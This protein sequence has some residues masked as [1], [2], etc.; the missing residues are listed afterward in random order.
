MRDVSMLKVYT[1]GRLTIELHDEGSVTFV[2]QKAPVLLVYLLMHPREHSR[3]VLAEMF[4]SDTTTPQALKNLR[5]VLSNLQKL[6]GDYLDVTRQTLAITK[7]ESIWFDK[8]AFESR[9]DEIG[10]K[11]KHPYSPRKLIAELAEAINL[12]QGDFLVGVKTS[13]APQLDTWIMLEQERL[14]G[15]VA[16]AM[17]K[18][19]ELALAS[20]YYEQGIEYGRKLLAIEPLWEEAHRALMILLVKSGNRT[21]ALQQY[22]ACVKIL[23]IELDIEPDEETQNVYRD[24]KTGRIRVSTEP[25]QRPTNLQQP[26]TPYVA[27]PSVIEKI[28][29]L[30][31]N[32][33]CRLVTIMGQGGMGKTRLSQ[34]LGLQRLEDYLDGVYFVPLASVTVPEVLPLAILDALGVDHTDSRLS[35]L[36]TLLSLLRR[37]HVLLILDNFEHLMNKADV[38]STILG[39][40]PYVQIVVTSREQLH[41]QGEH[42][43]YLRALA[44]AES[45]KDHSSF[46]AGELFVQMAKLAQVDFDA[47]PHLEA[48][49]H[50]CQLVDGL[51]LAIVIAAAWVRFLPPEAIAERIR[52]SLEFLTVERRDFPEHH[53]GIMAL[54]RMTWADLSDHERMIMM[55]IAVFPGDF[56]EVAAETISSATLEDMRLLVSKSLLQADGQGRYFLHE[57]LRRFALEQSEADNIAYETRHAHRNYY[58]AWLEEQAE[59]HVPIHTLYRKIDHE[60]HNVTCIDW[61]EGEDFHHAVLDHAPIL[62]DYWVMRGYSLAEGVRLLNEALP[63]ADNTQQKAHALY[64]TGQLLARMQQYDDSAPLL[65]M[66]LNH[67]REVGDVLLEAKILN[68]LYRVLGAQGD[69]A[70][71]RLNLLEMV[72]VVEQDSNG[73]EKQFQQILSMAYSNLGIVHM[74]MDDPVDAENYTRQALNLKDEVTDPVGTAL[75]H[76]TL[77]V[78]ALKRD[79]YDEAEEQ[80]REALRIASDVGHTRHQ[81]IYSGN[82]AEVLHKQGQYEQAYRMYFDTLQIAYQI[83]NNKTCLNVLEQLTD[84]ALDMNQPE[85]AVRLLGAANKLRQ[86]TGLA[87]EPRQQSEVNRR[88]T[89]LQDTVSPEA[90]MG[91]RTLDDVMSLSEAVVYV[92]DGL[93]KSPKN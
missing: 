88:Y 8:Q 75:C 78:I 46:E 5:T 35:P 13:N 66:G 55:K 31:D 32:P 12:Y 6:L 44:Y 68:E 4:W 93:V 11:Q 53:R 19:V 52:E 37:K 10:A 34:H 39:H 81:T 15:R 23:Q 89:R 42:V 57:L 40:A 61:L 9:L 21:A 26:T 28:N 74:Q 24:I 45:K 16:N 76:N 91:L 69:Y 56:D 64:R 84:I 72:E 17:L 63:Y 36:D 50:I 85:R 43:F 27:T 80:F 67:S 33:K 41:L 79:G 22:E 29:S 86:E 1:L 77:G 70:N 73:D 3:E 18:L 58:R 47:T 59:Q 82:L 30:L 71:A 60:Y 25:H 87:V 7:P 49:N 90:F 20:G 51:P 2:S 14:R 83:D 48:I 65:D 62:A 92:K 38:L 54:L